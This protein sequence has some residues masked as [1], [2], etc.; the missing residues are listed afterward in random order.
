VVA[1]DRRVERE[2]IPPAVVTMATFRSAGADPLV[3]VRFSEELAFEWRSR[4]ST[5]M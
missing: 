4:S 1:V 5:S 2:T 3:F